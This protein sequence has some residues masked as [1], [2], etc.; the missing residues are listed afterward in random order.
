MQRIDPWCEVT[1]GD[2]QAINEKIKETMWKFHEEFGGELWQ[3][4]NMCY[5]DG[6]MVEQLGPLKRV[7]MKEHDCRRGY[8]CGC[9]D[10]GGYGS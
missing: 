10:H 8:Y 4:S 9:G 6:A 3:G 5:K 7:E 1:P 2:E